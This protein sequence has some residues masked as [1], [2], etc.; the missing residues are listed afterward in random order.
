MTNIIYI[1]PEKIR[2]NGKLIT[3]MSGSNEHLKDL[4]VEEQRDLSEFII[5]LHRS[6]LSIDRSANTRKILMSGEQIL[7]KKLRKYKNVEIMNFKERNESWL[8]V[9]PEELLQLYKKAIE[10]LRRVKLGE[11]LTI[12]EDKHENFRISVNGMLLDYDKLV[13]TNRILREL[14]KESETYLNS[15]QSEQEIFRTSKDDGKYCP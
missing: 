14:L 7:T 13:K 1:S 9:D 3:I 5:S 8:F 11:S 10:K 12:H 6:V 2:I 15:I 4:T